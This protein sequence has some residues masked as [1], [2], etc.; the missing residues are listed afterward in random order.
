MPG[1][2]LNSVFLWAGAIGLVV[3]LILWYRNRSVP[4]LVGIGVFGYLVVSSL[5]VLWRNHMH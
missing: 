1:D 5:V 3:C 4:W 2:K